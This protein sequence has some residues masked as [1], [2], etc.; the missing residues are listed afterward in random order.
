M[1]YS[2][3]MEAVY[4][5]I[6]NYNLGKERKIL[7]VFDDMI[8]D[9]NNKKLNP[10]VTE[11]FIRGRKL[12][13]SIVFITQSYFKVPKDV[14]LNSTHFFITRIPNKRQL[15]QIALNHSSDIDFKDFI[16]IYKKCTAEPYSFLLNGTTLPLDDP[17]RFRE[18]LLE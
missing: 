17:L 1:E 13:I 16:K 5:N 14:R 11:L 7:I 10:V 6:E 15:Q 8:A 4:K 3:D 9:I 18:N 12:N 2:S